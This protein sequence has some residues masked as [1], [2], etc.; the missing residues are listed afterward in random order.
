MTPAVPGRQGRRIPAELPSLVAAGSE[1]PSGE[2]HQVPTGDGATL[3]AVATSHRA[4]G[5]DL[6]G[7]A[8]STLGSGGSGWTPTPATRP[9]SSTTSTSAR[10]SW[11]PTSPA[12]SAPW[13]HRRPHPPTPPPAWPA[14]H[15]LHRPQGLGDTLQARLLA[16]IVLPGLLLVLIRRPRPRRRLH[17]HPLRPPPQPRHGRVRPPHHGHRPRQT[18]IDAPKDVLRSDLR[19]RLHQVT[20]PT[21]II[22]GTQ[23]RS[24]KPTHA[25]TLAAG[26]PTSTLRTHPDAGHPVPLERRHQEV[27]RAV[28]PVRV[29]PYREMIERIARLRGHHPLIVEVPVLSPPLLLPTASGDAG[30][31]RWRAPD[32][33][34]EHPDRRPRR[35]TP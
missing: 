21:P 32:R 34:A 8:R 19:D 9:P 13:S 31:R 27:V 2:T 18:A 11:S 25:R 3:H 10:A 16:R 30:Q 24:G 4:I 23:D 28:T 5:D 35:P 7:H 29:R 22:S 12:A 6:R 26:I 15:D 1:L 14:R 17:P 33:R 20:L